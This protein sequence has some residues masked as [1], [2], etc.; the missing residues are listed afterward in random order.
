MK[1]AYTGTKKILFVQRAVRKKTIGKHV[2]MEDKANILLW[3]WIRAIYQILTEE[4][5][6]KF[7][8]YLIKEMKENGFSES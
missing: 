5:K 3:C 1:I 8:E 2:N 4:Q 6:K 7:V